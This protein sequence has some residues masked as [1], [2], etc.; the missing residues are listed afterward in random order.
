[1]ELSEKRIGE[2]VEYQEL[3]VFVRTETRIKRQIDDTRVL[4]GVETEL[5]ELYAVR[6]ESTV[7]NR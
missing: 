4:K 3:L 2:T 7:K 6:A 1:M 5:S